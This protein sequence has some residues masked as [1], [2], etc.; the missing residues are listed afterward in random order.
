M[1]RFKKYVTIDG[2]MERN[3]FTVAA[4]TEAEADAQIREAAERMARKRVADT[5]CRVPKDHPDWQVEYV[6][7]QRAVDLPEL[8]LE[9]A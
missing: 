9:A 5:T 2:I 1:T 4:E 3:G 7:A 8:V 6:A